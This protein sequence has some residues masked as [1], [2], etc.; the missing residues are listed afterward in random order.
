MQ[1]PDVAAVQGAFAAMETANW[2]SNVES[3]L[4]HVSGERR[5]AHGLAAD[6]FHLHSAGFQRSAILAA[7]G[8]DERVPGIAEV[9]LLQR[10]L[11]GGGRTVTLDH[12]A[13]LH[14]NHDDFGGYVSALRRR[15][16]DVGRLWRLDPGVA[17]QLYPTALLER[18]GALVRHLRI[19]LRLGGEATLSLASAMVS[20]G[21][22]LRLRRVT[23]SAA[24]RAAS[25]AVR[26]GVLQGYCR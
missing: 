1:A 5:R 10:I 23:L 7:G 24:A 17:S 14:I 2:V 11:A 3:R 9:P 12:P 19:P 6:E 20:A 21:R 13:V 8:F 22:V 15:G 16:R 25:W 18:H 4:R 26:V